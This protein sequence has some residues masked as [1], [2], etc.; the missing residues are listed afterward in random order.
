MVSHDLDRKSQR[1][2]EAIYNH[3]G[4]AQ[5]SEIM[6]YTGIE[7]NGIVHYRINE[8]LEPQ[9][10]VES[11][12]VE[13]GDR[14]LGV[15]ISSLT[16]AGN[17]VVGQIFEEGNGPTLMQEMEMLRSE[18]EDLRETVQLYEGHIDHLEDEIEAYEQQYGTID[19]I[20]EMLNEAKEIETD[21]PMVTE[22]TIEDLGEELSN[23]WG[24]VEGF[25][26]DLAS[27]HFALAGVMSRL[28]EAG[29]IVVSDEFREELELDRIEPPKPDEKRIDM[30][31][32]FEELP[33]MPEEPHHTED[34]A[35]AREYVEDRAD[36]IRDGELVMNT[37][38][39]DTITT[40]SELDEL[41]SDRHTRF[42]LDPNEMASLAAEWGLD[43]E[44]QEGDSDGEISVEAVEDGGRGE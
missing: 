14:P 32:L 19:E 9:G 30:G 16:D 25:L 15:K 38:N 4:D 33:E 27:K 42:Y 18:V 2:L 36:E 10:L 5:T 22:V 34:V 13:D 17:K 26:G 3:G 20:R 43:L 37:V 44:G 39:C 6:E 40:V 28:E 1:I 41:F 7:K 31:P 29:L 8:K 21:G 23:S 35:F 11:H 12:K 24:D